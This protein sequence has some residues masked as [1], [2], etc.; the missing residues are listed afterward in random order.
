[1]DKWI[2]HPHGG[3]KQGG[4]FSKDFLELVVRLTDLS[5]NTSRSETPE[6]AARMRPGMVS[7]GVPAIDDRSDQL[8]VGHRPF[9]LD[10]K[11]GE[12]LI[13]IEKI[14]NDRRVLRIGTVIDGEPDLRGFGTESLH[15]RTE[16]GRTGIENSPQK[17]HMERKRKQQRPHADRRP[18]DYREQWCG[19]RPDQDEVS[20]RLAFLPVNVISINATAAFKPIAQR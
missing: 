5:S 9:P 10:E 19:K 7:D 1:M 6:R 2:L 11:G 12:S 3:S 13:L 14:E 4:P 15:H 17:K 18:G 16:Q 20:D 8:G